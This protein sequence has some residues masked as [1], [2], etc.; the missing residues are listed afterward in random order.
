M[1]HFGAA[2]IA[3]KNWKA[4]WNSGNGTITAVASRD[5]GRSR[6]FIEACQT[7]AHFEQTP[8]ALGYD[9]L[10]AARDVDAVYIPLPTGIRGE[11]VRR[12]A[13]A[14]NMSFAKSPAQPAWRN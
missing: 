1:G 13:E 6:R 8:R 3:Q 10:L 11:W 4:I 7:Q 9:E 5:P 14:G 2:N 12:A